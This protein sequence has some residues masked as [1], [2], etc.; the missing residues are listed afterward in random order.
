LGFFVA[1]LLLS[2]FPHNHTHINYCHLPSVAVLVTSK[3]TE[4]DTW[5]TGKMSDMQYRSPIAVARPR[6]QKSLL[7]LVRKE[8]D[9][10]ART[11]G[12]HTTWQTAPATPNI[13]VNAKPAS[14]CFENV[15][16][17]QNTSKISAQEHDAECD[18]EGNSTEEDDGDVREVDLGVSDDKTVNHTSTYNACLLPTYSVK[19]LRD[20]CKSYNLVQSGKKAD[21]IAR[22]MQQPL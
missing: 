11:T 14:P 2:F 3:S 9:V 15:N 13:H 22:L 18:T 19:Q 20:L 4:T 7:C 5:F 17:P 12:D 16:N 6:I 21:L 1:F 8:H 10:Q